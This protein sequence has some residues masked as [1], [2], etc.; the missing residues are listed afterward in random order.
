MEESLKRITLYLHEGIVTITDYTEDSTNIKF[1]DLND[2]DKELITNLVDSIK[3]GR[4]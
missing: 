1:E 2:T 4:Y 3:N